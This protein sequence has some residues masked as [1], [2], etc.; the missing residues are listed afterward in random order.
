MKKI[1]LLILVVFALTGC[2]ATVNLDID[3]N[4]V[5]EKISINASNMSEY[6]K[7]KNWNGFP[8]ETN[9]DDFMDNYLQT[10]KTKKSGVRYYNV[11]SNDTTFNTIV[12][13][14]FTYSGYRNSTIAK[15]CF[16]YVNILED[17]NKV[18]FS[19]SKGLL[20]S[21]YDFDLVINTPYLVTSNNANS[22]NTETNT[23]TWNVTKKNTSNF[24]VF[25][26][27]DLSKKYKEDNQ[28]SDPTSD[29]SDN[30]PDTQ[31]NSDNS[32]LIII[33]VLLL[34]FIIVGTIILITK[35]RKA[36][37]L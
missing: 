18:I 31:S 22:V 16:K 13:S 7:V 8:L 33:G 4:S 1:L 11:T 36:S 17:G 30:T 28:T 19:T 35:K 14:S 25:F 37:S 12:S 34:I 2:H 20:C 6:S 5:N 21:F 26:E 24:G 3:K 9:Y 15:N 32:I 27:I 29:V 23:Y 10:E